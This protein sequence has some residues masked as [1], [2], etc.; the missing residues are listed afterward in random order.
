MTVGNRFGGS[1]TSLGRALNASRTESRRPGRY[2]EKGRDMDCG[3]KRQYEAYRD[4]AIDRLAMA[5]QQKAQ[6]GRIVTPERHSYRI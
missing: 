5:A 1:G 6:D 4:A 2:V 3:W